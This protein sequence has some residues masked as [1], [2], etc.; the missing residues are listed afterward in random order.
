MSLA[1]FDD[2]LGAGPAL[3]AAGYFSSAGGAPAAGIARWDGKSWSD[4]GGGTAGFVY[5]LEVFDDGTGLAL[6]AGGTFTAVGGTEAANI[7]RWDGTAW[8]ALSTGTDDVLDCLHVFDDGGGSSACSAGM[9][10]AGD[11]G[12]QDLTTPPLKVSS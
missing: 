5:D 11:A 4:V 10:R 8:S 2:G 12:W 9:T 6:Y 7:A 1:V 3:Y